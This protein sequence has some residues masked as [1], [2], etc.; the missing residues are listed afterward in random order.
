VWLTKPW[1]SLSF[2]AVALASGALQTVYGRW[3]LLGLAACLVGDVL[4]IPLGRPAVFKSGLVAFL[5]GHVAFLCAF[6]S[7]T[8]DVRWLAAALLLLGLALTIVWR[9]LAPR[10]PADLKS[11]VASYFIV[12]GAMSACACAVTGAGGPVT[13]AL[14]ALAFAASDVSVARD[15]FVQPG[16]VNR[17]WGLPLY[18]LAQVLLAMTP[19]AIA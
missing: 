15:R 13:V 19:A 6:L 2:I 10:L 11:A 3:I 7:T 8:I 12:I 17:A 1:A 14:G 5:L 16:F 18:Y 9:W 4:L